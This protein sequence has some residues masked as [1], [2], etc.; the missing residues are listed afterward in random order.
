MTFWRSVHAVY[1]Y[2]LPGLS[3]LNVPLLDTYMISVRDIL[4][5]IPDKFF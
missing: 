2:V 1:Q 5:T 4:D 3:E